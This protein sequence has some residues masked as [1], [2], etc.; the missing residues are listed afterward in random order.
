MSSTYSWSES[1]IKFILNG[2]TTAYAL[3]LGPIL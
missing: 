1:T 3:I 2:E